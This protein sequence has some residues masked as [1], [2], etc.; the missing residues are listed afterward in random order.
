MCWLFKENKNLNEDI[1]KVDNECNEAVHI[2]NDFIINLEKSKFDDFENKIIE[3]L[4][5][6]NWL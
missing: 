4:K 5:G 2:L 3:M 1:V 6:H